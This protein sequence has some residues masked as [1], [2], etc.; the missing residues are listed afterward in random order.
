ME[1]NSDAQSLRVGLQAFIQRRDELA[2]NFN[3]LKNR[4][5][6]ALRAGDARQLVEVENA[7]KTAVPDL[8]ACCA[9]LDDGLD[10]FRRQFEE[11]FKRDTT[12]AH[13]SLKP[14][15][16]RLRALRDEINDLE[17]QERIEVKKCAPA[18]ERITNTTRRHEAWELE[19]RNASRELIQYVCS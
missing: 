13:Q 18:E 12:A 11:E 16:A 19:Q 15:R 6:E 17:E 2:N 7:L 3:R 1:N 4:K 5:A 14:I 10:K 9:D 8:V